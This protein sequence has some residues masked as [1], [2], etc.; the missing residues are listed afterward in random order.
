MNAADKPQT[1]RRHIKIN[2]KTKSSPEFPTQD[3]ADEWYQAQKERK[4]LIKRRRLSSDAPTFVVY[5]AAWIKK[6]MEN[7]GPETWQA[8][9]QRLRDYLLPELAD[10]KLEEITRAKCRAVLEK[11]TSEHKR[12]RSTRKRVQVLLSKIFNDALNNDPP[13]VTGN[14]VTRL[15]FDEKR[16]G[17][18]TPAH[19]DDEDEI[20]ALMRAALNHGEMT[21]VAASL[22]LFA[23][24]R[25]SE[26]IALRWR[27]IK[28]KAHTIRVDHKF[29]SARREVVKG[30][31]TGEDTHRDVPVPAKLIEILTAW[32]K[33]SVYTAETDF[34]LY[35][36]YGKKKGSHVDP[37]IL[38]DMIC[39]TRAAI[40]R[41]DLGWHSLRHTYGRL[42]VQRTGNTKALQMILG[43]SSITTTDLYAE[44]SSKQIQPFSEAMSM[45]ISV[46]LTGP[47]A[48]STHDEGSNL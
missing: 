8:D 21:F 28:W 7:Y 31:K 32:R 3:E 46:D 37:R 38:H 20:A 11:V 33:R 43:H 4:K 41:E 45:E 24:L 5:A 48:K 1:F 35:S 17:K 15:T 29:V 47:D 26:L 40:G 42:F 30:T 25:K 13:L 19:I 23:G 2:G 10:M 34:I 16:V 12:S 39:A 6:R 27:N 36:D 9:N 22:V 44:L 14:P 18:K